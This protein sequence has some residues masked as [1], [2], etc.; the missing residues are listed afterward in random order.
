VLPAVCTLQLLIPLPL[1]LLLLLLLLHCQIYK[2]VTSAVLPSVLE[3]VHSR[4]AVEFIRMCLDFD[5]DKRPSAADLLVH[6]FLAIQNEEEDNEEVRLN[7]ISDSSTAASGGSASSGANTAQLLEAAAAAV[8][9]LPDVNHP[10]LV[11][12]ITVV[13]SIC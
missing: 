13:V 4:Q 10:A 7:P 11:S 8:V 2:R 12:F 6:P 3:R 1:L 5:P 9:H